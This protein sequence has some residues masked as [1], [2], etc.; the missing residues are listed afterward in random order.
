M[1]GEL[2]F[3]AGEVVAAGFADDVAV[4]RVQ[5]TLERVGVRG[6]VDLEDGGELGGGDGRC[7]AGDDDTGGVLA[8]CSRAVTFVAVLVDPDDPIPQ[9]CRCRARW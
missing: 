7:D 3:P 1:L 8:R 4:G 9:V 6:G 5:D 2:E